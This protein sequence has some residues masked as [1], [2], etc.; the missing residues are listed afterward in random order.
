VLHT[1]QCCMAWQTAGRK[2]MCEYR[3]R[4]KVRRD[5]ASTAFPPHHW[6]GGRREASI[7][8]PSLDYA[9]FSPAK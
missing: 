7:Q 3:R 5:P 4:R 9:G 6:V 8:V 1:G 2:S